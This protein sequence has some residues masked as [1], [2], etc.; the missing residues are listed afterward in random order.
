M[1]A[2]NFGLDGAESAARALLPLAQSKDSEVKE[3]LIDAIRTLYISRRG[4]KR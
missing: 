1:L 4:E 2:H 3:A